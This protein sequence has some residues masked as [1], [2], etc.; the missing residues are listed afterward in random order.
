VLL[1]VVSRNEPAD[2]WAVF[3]NHPGMVLRRDQITASRINW[4]PKSQNLRELASEL[5]LGLDSFVILDDDPAQR[6]EVEANAPEVTVLPLPSDPSE[7][8]SLVNRLW[9]FDTADAPT[10]EDRERAHMMQAEQQRKAAL[11][12]RTSVDDYLRDLQLAVEMREANAFDLPRV[13]QLEQKT[14]QFNL[15]L[16]RRTL[17][18]LKPLSHKHPL[19]VVS[20]RDRFGDYGLIA[21]CLITPHEHE[22]EAFVLDTLV[23]SCRAL[24]RGIEEAVLTGILREISARGGKRLV[25]RYMAGPRNQ[26]ALSFLRKAGFSER[27]GGLF[28]LD[29]R[30][31]L[32]IPPHIDWVVR[33]QRLAG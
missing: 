9:L 10:A 31:D 24:G 32:A 11:E 17:E 22:P 7:Y 1:A 12:T 26:P 13:A 2:V 25:A 23:M 5:N 29:V 6:L 18:E 27:A 28:T 16:R 14:N 8:A 33:Q 30:G 4:Q 15:S 21:T 20:A 19:F 3:E